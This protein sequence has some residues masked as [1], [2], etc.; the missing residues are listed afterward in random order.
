M[1]RHTN[2]IRAT[3]GRKRSQND[4]RIE[5]KWMTDGVLFCLA[6]PSP[7]RLNHIDK[8]LFHGRVNP[9]NLWWWESNNK[10]YTIIGFPMCFHFLPP[11]V[12]F[13]IL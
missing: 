10:Y 6:T 3:K 7:E 12:F 8:Q 5:G 13:T 1:N 2:K 4:Q 9:V 11:E